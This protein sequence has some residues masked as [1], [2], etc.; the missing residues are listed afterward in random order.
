VIY[1]RDKQ[2]KEKKI[3]IKNVG[4]VDVNTIQTNFSIYELKTYEFIPNGLSNE[5]ILSFGSKN[6]A[7]EALNYIRQ[8]KL[9]LNCLS[10]T[11]YSRMMLLNQA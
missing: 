7:K 2:S 9:Q 1:Y 4:V 6:K 5:L 3:R 11:Q 8:K 10:F